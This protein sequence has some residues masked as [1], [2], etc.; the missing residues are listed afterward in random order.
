MSDFELRGAHTEWIEDPQQQERD[1]ADWEQGEYEADERVERMYR[2]D[3]PE[4]LDDL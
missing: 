4:T 1:R 3:D 2:F